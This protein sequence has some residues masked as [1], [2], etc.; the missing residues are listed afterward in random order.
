MLFPMT[1][2]LGLFGGSF[3]PV[4]RG[5][6]TLALEM[7]DALG[8]DELR[9]IP[10]ARPPHKSAVDLA[11]A[12]DRLRMVEIAIRGIP[13]LTVSD[14][15]IVRGAP[16]FTIDTAR[17]VALAEPDAELYFVIGMDSLPELP[18]WRNAA[19]LARLV[20]FAVGVRPGSPPP[21]LPAIRQAIPGLRVRCV[22]TTP[23]D[24][25]STEIRRIL[26]AGGDP[27]DALPPG[28]LH[29]IR[30]RGLYAGPT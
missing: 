15:E 23:V 1:R 18:L 25:S 5:H 8:T 20:T 2:R 14:M 30:R 3:N 11:P 28:I 13:G 16:S 27:G 9:L 29:W 10:N 6:V 12:D 7:R 24:V 19:E 17:A 22:D 26:R 21:S 4:H